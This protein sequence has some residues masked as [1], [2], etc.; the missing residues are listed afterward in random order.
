M[1]LYCL[2]AEAEYAL[3][4]TNVTEDEW[5][6]CTLVLGKFYNFFQVHRNVIFERAQFNRW[7]QI[8]GESAE[9]YIAELYNIAEHCNYGNLKSKMMI[10]DC[11]VVG[12]LNKF[13]SEC[14]QLDPD[15]TLE[16]AKKTVCQCEAVQEQ[17][18]VLSEVIASGLNEVQSSHLGSKISQQTSENVIV[19]QRNRAS[20]ASKIVHTVVRNPT[21]KQNVLLKSR[22]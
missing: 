14:L 5:K 13:L 21:P 6:D 12:I 3:T 4:S 20:H 15:L 22:V 7:C 1:L 10:R 9:Q 18:Q 8:P 11:L 17:Q 19:S 16:K 2:S